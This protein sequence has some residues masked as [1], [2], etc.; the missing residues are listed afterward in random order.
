MSAA[1]AS[2]TPEA[3]LADEAPS[4]EDAEVASMQLANASD[5]ALAHAPQ[6]SESAEAQV[7]SGRYR[8]SPRS[9]EAVR[10]SVR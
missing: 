2:D 3:A 7:R 1:A 5:A 10:A 6:A 4:P 8:A 9:R